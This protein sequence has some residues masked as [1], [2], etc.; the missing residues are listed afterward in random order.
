MR[1]VIPL[2][3][4]V[5]GLLL[6]ACVPPARPP[7]PGGQRPPGGKPPSGPVQ[8][9]P[10]PAQ[11][12]P[13]TVPQAGP[14]PTAA[15]ECPA[16]TGETTSESPI[17]AHQIYLTT[18][19]DGLT[20]EEGRLILDHASMPDL[21]VGPDGALWVYFV[22]GE[23]GRHGIFAARQTAS[24][25]W[26]VVGC[27]TLDG[28]FNGN[29]VD[30]DVTRL[31]DGRY[32]LVYF[33]GNFVTRTLEEGEPNP[34]FSAVS[35]DGLHFTVERQIFA[36]PGATDPS[37]VQ[38]PDGS[39]LLAVLAQQQIVFA[40]S[41]DGQTFTEFS[42]PI[43]TSG[44]PELFVFSD[45]SVGLYLGRTF[46]LSTDG[47]ETWQEHPERRGPGGG[48]SISLIAQP[49]GGYT[50]VYLKV[51]HS[52]E[53]SSTSPPAGATPAFNP[54]ANLTAEQEACLKEAWGEE[55]FQAITTF[56]RPPTQE[57]EPAITD[58]GL[59]PPAGGPGGGPGGQ[60]N[61]P[62]GGGPGQPGGQEGN[63]SGGL[64]GLAQG[65]PQDV[66][67]NLDLTAPYLMAFLACD[68]TASSCD[69]PVDHQVYLAQSDDGEHW[70]VVPG[71]KPFQGS[72][73]DVI[74]RGNVLY[75][76]TPGA[77]TRYH[78]DTGVLE[79]TQP[80]TIEGVTDGFV[81]PS[82]ILDAQGRLTMFFYY[83]EPNGNLG[84]CPTGET[85]CVRHVGSAT[86]VEGSDGT[87]FVLD[88]GQRI[89][90]TLDTTQE[91]RKTAS[92]PD[93]F[94][95]GQRYVLYLS[96]GLSVSV[97]TSPDLRGTYSLVEALPDGLL[98]YGWGGVPAGYFDPV[99]GEYWTYVHYASNPNIPLV[100]RLA[101]HKSLTQALGNASFTTILTGEG[102]GLGAGWMV[103]SPSFAL[104]RP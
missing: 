16:G 1:R 6:A 48:G 49:E 34:I 71:W 39:W 40:R 5:F 60:G 32:R 46:Y 23:P 65:N 87:R 44:I 90:V 28:Q 62:P 52:T 4:L 51:A 77:V 57:E 98:S 70:Q 13:T 47:G 29:A 72:V 38:L 95:D 84:T 8:A 91:T 81:D 11:P 73:P 12:S 92:D 26:E 104:N 83:G 74:R 54:F 7:R 80:V 76:Y 37:L 20:F 56:Q 88:Q 58:C 94:Y 53:E 78:L 36:Y 2:G 82:L 9:T 85:T 15:G 18:S 19:R 61:M 25:D 59:T 63:P 86:E 96:H 75:I 67:L 99:S 3:V 14:S 42:Q 93:I 35:D 66:T 31:P 68:T 17:Y 21:V 50:F 22:N 55:A 33:Q 27:V 89:T 103:G 101:R 79:A 69:T 97:W 43:S 10:L 64:A 24:G 102:A 30:P 45:G 100:I 41:E